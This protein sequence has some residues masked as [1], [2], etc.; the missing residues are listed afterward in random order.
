MIMVWTFNYINI[1]I[2]INITMGKNEKMGKM[3]KGSH[4]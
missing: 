3:K 4:L 1:N 2:N